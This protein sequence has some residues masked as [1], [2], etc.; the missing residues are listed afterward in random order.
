VNNDNT[1]PTSPEAVL[2]KK[3]IITEH[4][5]ADSEDKLRAMTKLVGVTD[6]QD[7]H[8][9][10]A[11][12]A[13]SVTADLKTA[14]SARKRRWSKLL[15]LTCVI[16][17]VLSCV[18]LGLFIQ[19]MYV[20]EDW[21]SGLWLGVAGIILTVVVGSVIS[22]WRGLRQLKYQQKSRQTS[23]ELFNTPAIGLGQDHCLAV[24]RLMPKGYEPAIIAWQNSINEHHTDSE[25]I[26]L[27]EHLVIAKVDQHALAKV[28]NNAGAASVMIA[29]SPFALVDMAIVLWRNVHMMN[30]ISEVYGVRLGY[31]GRV[32][33]I[34][35]IFQTMLYAGAAEIISDAGNYALGASVAGKLSTR[36]AQGMGAGVLTARIGLKAIDEC[37]PLPWLTVQKPGLSQISKKLISD[38]HNYLK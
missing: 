6:W 36:I 13:E 3:I 8:C 27:F 37:R 15:S 33:L 34:R 5:T 19:Q 14:K 2:K 10:S 32:A 28:M 35:R 38:L 16:I 21:L 22:E 24:A 11:T 1:Q 12:E 31:W 26:S 17:L 30:Q 29:V 25:I 7:I 4:S 23:L 18:E 20:S 9:T